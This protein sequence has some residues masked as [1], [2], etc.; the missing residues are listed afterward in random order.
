M[1]PLRK[2]SAALAGAL[3]LLVVASP[4]EAQVRRELNH[5]SLPSVVSHLAPV[6]R[7]AATNRLRLAVGLPLHNQQQ[8]D[9]TLQELHDPASSHY[10]QWLTPEQFTASFGPTEQEYR[11]VVDYLETHGLKVEAKYS[12]RVLVSASGAVPDIE[13]AFAVH[14]RVY[15]HPRENRTFYSADAVPSLDADVPVLGIS[16]LDNL[17]PPH[18]ISLAKRGQIFTNYTATGSGPGG[19]FIGKD[20]RAA[21]AP[22]VALDGTGQFVALIDG[23]YYSNDP[24]IYAQDA[25]LPPPNV[26]NIYVGGAPPGDPPPG[27]DDGEQSLDISMI[28][29]MAPR[30]TIMVYEG[31]ADA[32]FVQMALDNKAKQI[33]CSLGWGPPSPMLAQEFE[34][35]DAQGQAF[36][37]ASGDG[38][39]GGDASNSSGGGP[40][41]ANEYITLVGGTSLTTSGAGGPWQSETAWVGSGG[42]VCTNL[43]IPSYQQGISMAHNQGSTVYRNFPDVAIQ[44]D[45][46]IFFIDDGAPGGVGGT[47]AAAPLWAGYMAL[48]NQQAAAVGNPPVGFL[49][50]P[51][52]AVGKSSSYSSVMHDIT[53]GNDENSSYPTMFSA[54]SGYDLCTGWGSPRGQALINALAG[55]NTAPNFSLTVPSVIGSSVNDLTV[56]QGSNVTI[57]V[58][59]IPGNGFDGSVSLSALDLPAGVTASFNPASAA[60]TSTLTF[61]AA[62]TAPISPGATVTILGAGGGLTRTTTLNLSVVKGAAATANFSL[63]ASPGTVAVTPGGSST[64]T[65]MLN[66]LNG[67][68]GSVSLSASDLPGGVTASFNP[69]STTTGS[70]LTFTADADAVTETNTVTVTG[71]SGSLNNSTTITLIITDTNQLAAPGIIL[72][73]PTGNAA[74]AAPATVNLAASVVTNGNLINSVQFYANSSLIGQVADAPYTCAWT[75]LGNGSYNVF[76]Q[77]VYNGGSLVDSAAINFSVTNTSVNLGF[78]SPSLGMGSYQYNPSGA[79]WTFSGNAAVTNGSGIVAN[80]SALGNPNAPQGIQAA[81]IRGQ[82]SLSQT[83]TGFKPGTNY[84]IICSA[85]QRVGST[86]SWNAVIDNTVLQINNGP[87]ST[88]YTT[89]AAN[90]TASAPVHTLSFVGTDL[91]GGDNT[92]FLDNVTINP[93]ENLGFETPVIN[94][95]SYQYAPTGASWTFGGASP[96][97]SGILANGSAFSNPT[98]PQGVQAAFVQEDGTISQALSGLIPGTNYTVTFQAAERPGNAQSWKVTINGASIGSYNPGSGATAYAPYTASFTATAPTETLAFVGTDLAGGDNTIFID[99][100]QIASISPAAPAPPTGLTATAGIAQVILGWNSV[101][102]ATSYSVESSTVI[103]GPY[104]T[105][106]NVTGTNFLNTGLLNGNTYYYVVSAANASG[107]GAVSS[108]VSATPQVPPPTL[109]AIAADDQVNLSWTPSLGAVSYFVANAIVSGGPY[110]PVANVTVTN[111]FNTGL[112]NGTTYYY[113]VWA[114]TASGPTLCSSEVRATPPGPNLTTVSDFGFESPSLDSATFQYDPTG[115]AW[116]FNGASPN[117]SGLVANASGF[118]N[119][120]APE[121]VQAAFVQEYGSIA[122]TVS[123]FMPGTNYTLTFLAAERPGYSE[124]W[125]V[126]VNGTTVGTYNP[127]SGATAYAAY[128]AA[129]TATAASETLAFVGTDSAGGDNTVFIDDVQ[130]GVTGLTVSP[131][132]QVATNTLPVTAAD[133]V[134]GQ[135]TFTAGFM[136]GAPMVLQW[137]RI[138]GGVTNNIPGATN[139]ALTLADLQ[140]TNTASYQLQASNAFGSAVS[141]PS[142]L[143]VSSVPAAVNNV[144][145]ALASQTGTGS[146]SFAP[147]WTVTTNSSLIAGQSPSST[148]GNFSLEAPGRSVSSLTAG[149]NDALYVINGTSGTTT[150]TNYVTCGNGYGAG[151]L[152]IYTLTGS[153]SGYDLTNITVY[154]G[155]KDAGRDQQAYTVYYSTVAAPATFVLLG[156]LNYLPANPAGVQ[157][158]TRATLTPAVGVLAA[159]VAAIKFDFTTPASENGYCGYSEINLSGVPSPQPVRWAVGN[160]NWDTSTPNWELLSGGGTVSY[161]E[162][163]LAALDDSASGSSPITL[164]LTGNH[165]PSVLT[166]NSAKTYVLVGRFALTGGSLIKNGAGTLLLDNGGANG[167]N[168]V[169]I[170]NGAVQVGN[171]DTNGSLGTGNVTNN[172][173]LTFDRTDNVTLINLISG[174]GS[175]IQNGTGIVAVSAANTFAGNTTINSG[176]LALAGSGSIGASALIAVAAG[177]TLDASGRADQTLT[178]NSGQTL[179]GSGSVNGNLNALAG[180]TLAPGN[181][182]G[183]LTV[184]GSLTSNGGLLLELNRTNLQTSDELAS[185]NGVITATG[186][187]TVT[188]V[189]S[190]LQAGDLFQLFNQPVGGFSTVN[191]PPVGVNAW[192]NNLAINGTL[193]V[194]STAVPNLIFQVTGGNL[195]T[196]SWPADHTGWRLQVQTNSFA[197]GLGTNWIDVAGSTTANQMSLLIDPNDGSV[198]YRLTSPSDK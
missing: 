85:A 20:F 176:A 163:N 18:P 113:V 22:G 25:G 179:T 34:E 158:A 110:T 70:T 153:V 107:A 181:P 73:G 8:L 89:Y 162:N 35:F 82:G 10:H 30:A 50:P 125:K 127:G 57:M 105:V 100:V 96:N 194:V 79:S 40:G 124:S 72:T 86:Q 61:T 62:G 191:L 114:M 75:N 81:F 169:S 59:I 38:G 175:M 165:S 157:C 115:A 63:S 28:M 193:A 173:V 109:M 65:I 131:S 120:N 118:S 31:D 164:T 23:Q 55:T 69:A 108:Q 24:V 58:T 182:I 121:G 97:G 123:G 190:P 99:N 129:F 138:S 51:I 74:F 98:A 188:N 78:E 148:S 90:F 87:A 77:V 68:T 150:S 178:L 111:Y 160:G 80:G 132:P 42:A 32:C 154:G 49:N 11:S 60:S 177:A 44:A 166:N 53:T 33:S 64:S 172:G 168:S 12:N 171:N 2:I 156:T 47:S 192:A 13:K 37:A 142:S 6:G 186:A 102:G 84:T 52:Y 29:S 19:L 112:T 16:G 106:A 146:G 139:T 170:N 56:G 161:V 180:S 159:R 104:L 187:L 133:V 130:I 67:F 147:T 167:F 126:T 39:S 46:D 119:P 92:L 195:L 54:V 101:S 83:L 151:S 36:F 134:G 1:K 143:T 7:L 45:T 183:T 197:Q 155:W 88:N 41:A 117:G 4:T 76:A 94:A 189:G 27:T 152:V 48:V 122:Q 15:P 174:S 149:G 184:Q 137:Q 144:V 141:T 43:P 196:L 145:T 185:V 136:A 140:L 14:L 103:G 128:K 26:T 9:A 95:G 93:N 198:F 3:L 135:V 21:Y 71:T 91:S 5:G 17:E 66:A 116:T